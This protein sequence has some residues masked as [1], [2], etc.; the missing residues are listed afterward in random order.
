M[1]SAGVPIPLTPRLLVTILNLWNS[2]ESFDQPTWQRHSFSR[3]LPTCINNHLSGAAV[4][5]GNDH[6]PDWRLFS[7]ITYYYP[8][9]G[10]PLF[11][12]TR[13]THHLW[14]I[15]RMKA[16]LF[17]CSERFPRDITPQAAGLLTRANTKALVEDVPPRRSLIPVV[18]FRYPL[19]SFS[20]IHFCER[21]VYL[22][23]YGKV[24]IKQIPRLTLL[25]FSS[26]SVYK[27]PGIV[28]NYPQPVSCAG[29]FQ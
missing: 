6:L 13:K 5:C 10:K 8:A 1:F 24:K 22:P 2:D 12:M 29:N 15:P 3:F 25:H 26:L 17:V 18:T 16:L 7:D 14:F 4:E 9:P 20:F 27:E 23:L 11:V 28:F 19:L 21:A